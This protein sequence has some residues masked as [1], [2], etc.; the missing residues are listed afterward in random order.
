MMY[1]ITRPSYSTSPVMISP[2]GRP[3]EVLPESLEPLRSSMARLLLSNTMLE[4][5][6]LRNL[7]TSLDGRLAT[8]NGY[9]SWKITAIT[10]R[11]EAM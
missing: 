1:S 9:D 6:P 2:L 5:L 3:S 4:N 11:P 10:T 7:I 8:V